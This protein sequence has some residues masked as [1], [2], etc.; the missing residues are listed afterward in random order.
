M[1]FQLFQWEQEKK[2]TKVEE[3][4]HDNN[5]KYYKIKY[6]LHIW[7]DREQKGAKSKRNRM[8]CKNEHS[9]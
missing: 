2:K 1:L 9:E 5:K 7:L 6:T 3:K 8:S 4:S